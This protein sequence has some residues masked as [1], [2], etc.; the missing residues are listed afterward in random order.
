MRFVISRTS[1][2]GSSGVEGVIRVEDETIDRGH[3]EIEIN[4]L[5][6]LMALVKKYGEVVIFEQ[7]FMHE[8]PGIEIYDTWR[9]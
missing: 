4:T 1:S 5:E 9:E 2:I 8:L 7:A 6:E 3:D